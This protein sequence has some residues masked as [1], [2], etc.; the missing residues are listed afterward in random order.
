MDWAAQLLG[1]SPAFMNASG[2]GGGCIQVQSC[3]LLPTVSEL[4]D[5]APP[6][7]LP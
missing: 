6:L 7:I 5:R 3:S 2:V 1:L 4:R